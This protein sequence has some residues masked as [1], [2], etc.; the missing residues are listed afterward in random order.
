MF[1]TFQFSHRLPWVILDKKSLGENPLNAGVPQST[2]LKTMFY[3]L[4]INNLPNDATL[5]SKFTQTSDLRK[6]VELV[7]E[8]HPDPKWITDFK[9]GKNQL[10]SFYQI[11]NSVAINVKIYEF[12]L[13]E[14]SSFRMLVLSFSSKLG[15]SKI[16]K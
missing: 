7:S 11:N 4:Y 14:K 3:L 1:L 8:I 13:D 12:A 9:A 15:Q 5:Y 6:Q 10:V 2:I 16:K